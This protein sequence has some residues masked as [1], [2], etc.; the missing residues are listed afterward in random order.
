MTFP[1]GAERSHTVIFPVMPSCAVRSI[2]RTIATS[3]T[4]SVA[5][6]AGSNKCAR[7]TLRGEAK[8]DS[9][10]GFASGLRCSAGWF[11][12]SSNKCAGFHDGDSV[13]VEFPK[14]RRWGAARTRGREILCG[15]GYVR[16]GAGFAVI[17]SQRAFQAARVRARGRLRPRCQKNGRC[18]RPTLRSGGAVEDFLPFLTLIDRNRCHHPMLIFTM[19]STSCPF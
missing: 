11:A 18:D 6:N 19:F 7:F 17:T 3:D 13:R 10:A 14:V 5:G 1:W 8:S 16:R 9:R 15:V 12:G 4:A 2:A